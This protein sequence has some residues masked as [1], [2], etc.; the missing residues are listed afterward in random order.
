MHIRELLDIIRAC[1]RSRVKFRTYRA[2]QKL[3]VA[4]AAELADEADTTIERIHQVMIGD[5]HEYRRDTSLFALRVAEA[6]GLDAFALSPRGASAFDL[7]RER[8]ER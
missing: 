7:V 2:L 5:G 8:L 1:R 4:T 6:C 3:K